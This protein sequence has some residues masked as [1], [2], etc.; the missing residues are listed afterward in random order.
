MSLLYLHDNNAL[1]HIPSAIQRL[2]NLQVMVLGDCCALETLPDSLCRMTSLRSL[3]LY[4]NKLSTLPA[5][6]GQLENLTILDLDGNQLTNLPLALGRCVQLTRLGLN[7]NKL[8]EFPPFIES[9][10]RL[11]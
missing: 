6:V 8:Q 5:S 4:R 3:Y 1:T 7:E 9:L 11:E 2:E 10:T